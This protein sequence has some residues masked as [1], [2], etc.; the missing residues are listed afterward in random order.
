M[1][2]AAR[3]ESRTRIQQ[4]A[5]AWGVGMASHAEIDL[6]GVVP[7][8]RLAALRAVATL[9]IQPDHLLLD[10]LLLED[11]PAS[12]TSLIK[13]DCRSLSIAAASVLAKTAR[14]AWL[15]E[16]DSRYPGY[17]FARHKGYC[18]YE[19]KVMLRRLGPTPFHRQSFRPVWEMVIEPR[20]DTGGEANDE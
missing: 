12:Q 15:C 5:L 20:E 8:T 11:H 4:V 13:G 17:G 2:P 18:T 1:T 16:L 3:E 14:D 7:A 9:S 19:H 10:W 6:Y